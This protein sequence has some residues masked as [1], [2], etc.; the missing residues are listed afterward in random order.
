MKKIPLISSLV[1]FVLLCVSGSYWVLQFIKPPVRKITAP[2]AVLQSADVES[3]ATLFGGAMAVASNYQLKGI[4]L[5]NPMNQSVAI[6]AVDGKAN[7]AYPIN[8]EI[9]NGVRLVEV[10][11]DYVLLSDNGVNKRVDLPQEAKSASALRSPIATT[12]NQN[13]AV[14]SAEEAA[15][16][17]RSVN[18]KPRFNP[19]GRPAIPGMSATPNVITQPSPSTPPDFPPGSVGPTPNS[20]PTANQQDH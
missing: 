12:L 8:S 17:V 14:N 15:G 1:L 5:A 7:Q 16:A 19:Q 20:A 10:H 13:A 9:S 6:I 2:P 11:A 18:N 3:V 4:V